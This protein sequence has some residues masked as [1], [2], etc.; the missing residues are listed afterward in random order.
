[1][2]RSA[3]LALGLIIP[4]CLACPTV[5]GQ[6]TQPEVVKLLPTGTVTAGIF[7]D[8]EP[9]HYVGKKLFDY[10]N[11]GAELYLAYGFEDLGVAE[12]KQA[13][14]KLR[15]ALYKMGSAPEA[16]GI[17]THAARGRRVDLP[18]PNRLEPNMLSFY[19]GRYYVRVLPIKAGPD[20]ELAMI[21]LGRHIW[22][23]LPGKPEVPSAVASLPRGFVAGTLRYLTHPE[24]ARTTW[25]NGEGKPLLPDGATAVTAIYGGDADDIQLTRA[26]YPDEKAAV[27]ACRKLAELLELD[28]KGDDTKC[29]ATG[30]TPDDV[31][32]ALATDEKILRWASGPGSEAG[33][34][35]QLARIE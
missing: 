22:N 23:H 25:F 5:A 30:K 15:V 31:F 32:A 21:A 29:E 34:K 1:M 10:M 24:T 14:V 35:K 18:G 4:V 26:E 33:A 20:A 27:I 8:G 9:E 28:P 12:Y 16:Y 17:Y 3:I 6:A 7:S 13:D 19:K 11:G 2:P